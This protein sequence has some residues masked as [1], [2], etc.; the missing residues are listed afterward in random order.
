MWTP[1][2]FES[3]YDKIIATENLAIGELEGFWKLIRIEPEKWQEKQYGEE[4]G[5]FWVVAICGRKVIW[6]ND[7]E[8]GFNVS[9]YSKYGEIDEYWCN[10]SELDSAI[11]QL[12]SCIK[13]GDSYIVQAGSPQ[14]L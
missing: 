8:E 4:G 11:T 9:N 5:G 7:I 14:N 2:S 13:F 1:I 10:Q 6:Y 3:L 12:H